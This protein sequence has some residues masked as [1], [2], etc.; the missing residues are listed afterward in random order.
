MSLSIGRLFGPVLVAL[1]LTCSSSGW[2][3][4]HFEPYVSLTSNKSITTNRSD[5]TETEKIRERQEAGIRAGLS[6]FRLFKLNLSAGQSVLTTTI[7][8][9]EIIKDE[10]DEINFGS[11]IDTST[12]GKETKTEETQNKARLSLLFDPGFWIFIARLKIGV[13][14]RQRLL[15]VYQDDALVKNLEPPITFKPHAGVGL[16]VKL[17][18]RM[19]FMVE[20]SFYYYKFPEL[21]P[22]ERAATISYGIGI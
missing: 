9:S 2:A 22:F 7:S 14:A 1:A 19:Y 8:E 16:G 10:Y 11:E 6:F 15:K 13:T 17:A 20:Y 5:G 3:R 18:P 12:E 21:E 4:F